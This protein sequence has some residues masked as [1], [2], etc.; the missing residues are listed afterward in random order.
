MALGSTV[1]REACSQVSVHWSAACILLNQFNRMFIYS[2]ILSTEFSGTCF[3]IVCAQLQPY[4]LTHVDLPVELKPHLG[5][6]LW[7]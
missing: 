5:H 7:G 3:L 1:F 4:I 6:S 2:E